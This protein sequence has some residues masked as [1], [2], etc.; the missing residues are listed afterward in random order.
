MLSALLNA[1]PDVGFVIDETGTYVEVLANPDTESLLYEDAEDLIG[2][3][4][5]DLMPD[6]KADE[7]LEPLE[8]SLET[9]GLVTTEYA[10][11]VDD[12]RRWFEARIYPVDRENADR[13]HAIWVARDVTD[14]KRTQRELERR[15]AYTRQMLDGIDDVFYVLDTDGDLVDWNETLSAVTGYSDDQLATF[16]VDRF[17]A[18]ESTDRLAALLVEVVET[19]Q[20][21]AKLHLETRDGE[22]IPYEF[23]SSHFEDADGN[24]LVVGIGRDVTRRTERE[25]QVQ[26]FSR[27][28][29]HN[30]RNSMNV[31]AGASAV[32]AEEA[33][34]GVHSELDAIQHAAAD[35][36]EVAE[37]AKQV[38]TLLEEPPARG[39]VDL[40]S[41]I[42]RTVDR[43]ADD[44]DA[45]VA[46]DVPE[47]CTVW[48][49]S[50]I[51]RALAEL[52]ENALE[53]GS[54][55]P[56][57][58]SVGAGAHGSE[59]GDEA[60]VTVRARRVDRSVAVEVVDD[61]PGIPADEVRVLDDVDAI[62]PVQ[63]GSG[64][65]LWLATWVVRRSR[66][67]LEFET[68]ADGG[69]VA[70]VTLRAAD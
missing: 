45:T 40:A 38:A 4:F 5:H 48:A 53:H 44:H 29:R 3:A 36:L 51:E 57:T 61:G 46:V 69:T 49:S 19:G 20:A 59:P 21:E 58:R 64:V 13:R 67:T 11:P 60:S 65:G 52:V 2:N 32:L 28:L 68:P 17:V 1:F 14:R 39:R 22:R 35:L 37:K 63:H 31:I 6:E 16:D 50:S 7:L 70:R 18:A 42:R 56:Q 25:Q 62:T 26:V 43:T 23:Y 10:L 15:Q 8:R 47:D 54:T 27:L 41:A 34:P 66:G 12:E 33:P 30:L 9:D 55:S 24:E